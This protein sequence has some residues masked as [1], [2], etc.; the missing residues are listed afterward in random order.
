M[1]NILGKRCIYFG[2]SLL[3]IIPGMVVLLLWGLPL[4]IDFTGGSLMEI[5]FTPTNMPQPGEVIT[6]FNDLGLT[7]VQVT[8]TT[9][10]TLI[11]R[12]VFLDEEMRSEVLNHL[13]DDI[14]P[15]LVVLRFDSVGPTIGEEVS[16]LAVFA[17]GLA[18]L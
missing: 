12:S 15:N 1:L 9:D 10:N 14:D 5:Q 18:A 16:N 8:T 17:L 7:D 11:I 4:A 13:E 6:L 2:F 3:L